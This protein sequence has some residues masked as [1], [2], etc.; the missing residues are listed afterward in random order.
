[1]CVLRT[2]YPPGLFAGEKES[3]ISPSPC[4]S[5]RGKPGE[6]LRGGTVQERW[7]KRLL[8]PQTW[9]KR[10]THHDDTIT[11]VFVSV[12]VSNLTAKSARLYT[13]TYCISTK[14]MKPLRSWGQVGYLI[15]FIIFELKDKCEQLTELKNPN[16]WHCYSQ[17]YSFKHMVMVVSSIKYMK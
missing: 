3:R 6:K 8:L 1:M 4:R 2:C 5:C 17:F 14:T 12:P 13:C 7:H 16:F 15:I 9:A 11:C 10:S